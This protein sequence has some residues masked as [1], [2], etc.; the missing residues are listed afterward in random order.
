MYRKQCG[1]SK[2]R[3]EETGI[4]AK[5]KGGSTIRHKDSNEE[6]VSVAVNE[7]K[8]AERFKVEGVMVRGS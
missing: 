4:T 3:K 2:L 5:E 8:P 7:E 1:R 6:Y